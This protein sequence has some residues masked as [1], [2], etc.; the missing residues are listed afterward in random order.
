[1]RKIS[2]APPHPLV[3]TVEYEA[4]APEKDSWKVDTL[5]LERFD[6]PSVQWKQ[7]VVCVCIRC[8]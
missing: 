6:G 2:G 8:E 5:R 7:V 1:M 3:K 4:N